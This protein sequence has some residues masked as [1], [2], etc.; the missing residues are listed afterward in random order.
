MGYCDSVKK[1]PKTG[2]SRSNNSGIF[3]ELLRCRSP[4]YDTNMKHIESGSK[5]VRYTSP[6]IQN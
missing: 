6:E 1:Q 2:R 3:I 5:N 4:E